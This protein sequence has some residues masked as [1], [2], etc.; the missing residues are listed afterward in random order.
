MSTFTKK[1]FEKIVEYC[2]IEKEL[3]NRIV[4]VL[5]YIFLK[6]KSNAF[7]IAI[8]L[9][10]KVRDVRKILFKLKEYDLIHYIRKKDYNKR[11]RK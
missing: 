5:N 6:P 3:E 10:M 11:K 2:D 8:F 9:N 1:R 7:D 4:D